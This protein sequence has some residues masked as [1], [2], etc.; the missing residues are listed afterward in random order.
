MPGS[1]AL[2][3]ALLLTCMVRWIA[4]QSR[5]TMDLGIHLVDLAL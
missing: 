5:R 4:E 2:L 3:Q 1:Y